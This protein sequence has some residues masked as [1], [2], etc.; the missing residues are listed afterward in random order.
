MAGSRGPHGMAGA[1]REEGRAAAGAGREESRA[2][3]GVGREEGCTAAARLALKGRG[4]REV[5]VIC[6]PHMSGPRL[7]RVIVIWTSPEPINNFGTQNCIFGSL[8][9]AIT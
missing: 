7:V 5:D 3:A 8:R 1:G 4:R 9:T 2:A 6:G